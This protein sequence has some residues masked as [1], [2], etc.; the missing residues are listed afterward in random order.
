LPSKF[1]SSNLF[2]Q[3]EDLVILLDYHLAESAD[4]FPLVLVASSVDL[5]HLA[6]VID[7]IIT[8]GTQILA[9]SF[10]GVDLVF[11]SLQFVGDFAGVLDQA[12]HIL[13]LLVVSVF[14]DSDEFGS[15]LSLS[16]DEKLFPLGFTSERILFS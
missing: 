4:V 7:L 13:S 6:K 16:T 10:C 2:I 14:E 5:A 8:C 1:E 15:L 3:V 9:D 12:L 11:E